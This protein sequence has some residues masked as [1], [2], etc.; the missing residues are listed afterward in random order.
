[1]LILVDDSKPFGEA[2]VICLAKYTTP[3]VVNCMVTH[4]RGMV[5]ISMTG[6]VAEQAGLLPQMRFDNTEHIR[7]YTIS[8]DAAETTTGI[9]AEERSLSIKKLVFTR[10]AEGFKKPGH[11]FPV[12]A[13]KRGL[14]DCTSVIEGA[15]DCAEILGL[16]DEMVTVCDIL[17]E[18]GMMGD[19]SHALQLAQRLQ[20]SVVYLSDLLKYK[21]AKDGLIASK[22]T[23]NMMIDGCSIRMCIYELFGHYYEICFSTLELEKVKQELLRTQKWLKENAYDSLSKLPNYQISVSKVA[24]QLKNN[25][26]LVVYGEQETT[27]SLCTHIIYEMI[28]NDLEGELKELT[29]E[30]PDYK[31][32]KVI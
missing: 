2:A 31:Q 19:T 28:F 15:I 7:N 25:Q 30:A 24:Q 3:E 11:I 22:N 26:H 20:L 12:I 9:S 16:K 17:D 32:V 21:L 4:A 14:Y 1:M 23:L 8:I 5:S 18:D 10:T 13:N 29:K 27:Y 6:S